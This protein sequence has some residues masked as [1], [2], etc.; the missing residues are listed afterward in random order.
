MSEDLIPE[1]VNPQYIHDERLFSKFPQKIQVQNML[2]TKIVLNVK[3]KTHFCTQHVLN[4]YFLGNSMNNLLTYC[5]LTEVGI[6]A[7]EKDLPVY[8]L[9]HAWIALNEFCPKVSS[10]AQFDVEKSDSIV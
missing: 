5:G 9:L 7:S 6:R 8:H 2:C 4:F 1:S 3:T 10:S